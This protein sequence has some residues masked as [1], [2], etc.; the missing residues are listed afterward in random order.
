[1]VGAYTNVHRAF[2]Q[3]LL[4]R[5]YINIHDGKEML[6]AIRSAETES[7]VSK[8]SITAKDVQNVL[9]GIIGAISH[10]DLEL[11]DMLDQYDGERCWSVVNTADDEIIR[12]ATTH[13]PDEISYFKRLL[14]EMFDTNNTPQ[15]EVMAVKSMRAL[16][17]N[18]NPPAERES[19]TVATQGA[20]GEENTQV[21]AGSGLGLTKSEAEEALAKF[22]DEGWLERDNAGY[23]YLSTRALL[24]LELYL[25]ETYN[26]EE[27]VEHEDGTVTRGTRKLKIK[28]CDVCKY[29]HTMGQRCSN[30][31]CNIR[32]HT[33]CA[34]NLFKRAPAECPECKSEWR[35]DPVGPE[36]G[37]GSGGG[38][39]AGLRRSRGRDSEGV[40]PQRLSKAQMKKIEKSKGRKSNFL[41]EDDEEMEESVAGPSGSRQ[42][43]GRRGRDSDEQE[44]DDASEEPPR[45]LSRIMNGESSRHS[46]GG[47]QPRDDEDDQTEDNPSRGSR[48]QRRSSSPRSNA[49][50]AMQI[51]R[52]SMTN[53]RRHEEEEEDEEE[54]EELPRRMSKASIKSRRR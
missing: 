40:Q 21:V 25:V 13:T 31:S 22:I 9:T 47:H 42:S 27:E 4:I 38:G 23:H 32:I 29:I 54:E 5:P 46:S 30:L 34:D 7:E 2:L 45:K 26:V 19:R 10:F 41:G 24:E 15:A 37:K 52:E 50:S 16:G 33:H 1:M 20:N 3:G 48:R 53:G 51:K 28:H 11:R 49:R 6:A 36:A 18:R 12:F 14:D 17:L 39:A 43:L 35:G 44:N 8:D